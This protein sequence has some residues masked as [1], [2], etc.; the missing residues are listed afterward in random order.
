MTDD[1]GAGSAVIAFD[2]L[3]AEAKLSVPRPR[4]GAVSRAG[5]IETARASD[6]RVVGVT[7]PAGYG[8]STLLVEWA[9]A[10]DRPLAWVSLDRFDDDPAAL[11]TMLASAYV[12]VSP[13]STDLLADIGG[14]GVSVLGRAAPL[15]A[16]AFRRSPV[17]FVL[18]VDDLHELRSPA[19]HDVLGVAIAG[20]PQ[21][22]SSSPPVVPS[23]R[24]C[25]GY[26]LRVRRWST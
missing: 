2:A 26:G 10:E 16:S 8:K 12:G 24:I 20:I 11:L 18:M 21:A 13:G 25:R 9:Q 15:L 7:A 6:C 1:P 23:S 4:P 5:L 22:L 19:C 3:L 14:L 17:P